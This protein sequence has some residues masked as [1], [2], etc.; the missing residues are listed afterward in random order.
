MMTFLTPLK[1]KP[2]LSIALATVE[3]MERVGNCLSSTAV[4]ATFDVFLAS[5]AM[6]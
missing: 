3:S 5:L 1:S 6:D 4:M 2:K